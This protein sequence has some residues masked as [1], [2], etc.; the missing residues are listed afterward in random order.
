[1]FETLTWRSEGWSHRD[2]GF[3]VDAAWSD[4][5]PLPSLLLLCSRQLAALHFTEAAPALDAQLLP[6]AAPQVYDQEVTSGTWGA[7][8]A[9]PASGPPEVRSRSSAQVDLSATSAA[10][11]RCARS[12]RVL[13]AWSQPLAPGGWCDASVAEFFLWCV[14]AG[15]GALC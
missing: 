12:G 6:L 9:G 8:G 15:R 10:H 7:A 5:T 4:R 1:M 3:L 2:C 13:D 14:C 11:V